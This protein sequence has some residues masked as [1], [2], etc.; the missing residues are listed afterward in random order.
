MSGVAPDTTPAPTRVTARLTAVLDRAAF[1][2]ALAAVAVSALAYPFRLS[3]AA[4]G[5]FEAPLGSLP[6]FEAWMRSPV[7]GTRMAGWLYAEFRPMLAFTASPL[8]LKQSLAQALLLAMCCA[9]AARLVL[10]AALEPARHAGPVRSRWLEPGPWLVAVFAWAAARSFPL[11]K[12]PAPWWASWATPVP[13]A[14]LF[15][16][17]ALGTGVVMGLALMRTPRPDRAR[18]VF[19]AAVVGCGFVVSSIALMQNSN[20]GRNSDGSTRWWWF[21]PVFDDAEGRNRMGSLIGHNTGLSSWLLFPLCFAFHGAM[22]APTRSARARGGVLAAMFALVIVYAQSRAVWL[23]AAAGLPGAGWAI[24][25]AGGLRWNRRARWTTAA[26][27]LA[28]LAALSVAPSVNPLARQRDALVDRLRLSVF[29]RDQLVRET[30]LRIVRA[31]LPLVAARPLSGHG[32]GAFAWVYGPAQGEYYRANLSDPDLGMTTRRTDVAHNDYL[33]WLVETGIIGA[34]LLAMAL[35]LTARRAVSAVR[36]APSPAEA[37][38]IVALVAPCA[39]ISIH[40]LVDFP[41]HI[42]PIALAAIASL[43]LAARGWN[44]ATPGAESPFAESPRPPRFAGSARRIAALAA[45]LGCPL[46]LYAAVPMIGRI[47]VSD[48]AFVDGANWINTA[49]TGDTAGSDR[50]H[51]MGNSRG[52]LRAAYRANPFNGEVYEKLAFSN[53]LAGQDRVR[54]LR[55]SEAAG[56]TSES[57]ALKTAART[58]FESA[59][60]NTITQLTYGELR[61]HTTFA[62]LGQAYHALWRLNPDPADIRQANYLDSARRHLQTALDYNPGDPAS[63]LEMSNLLESIPRPEPAKAAALRARMFRLSPPEARRVFLA[64][65]AEAA[66]RGEFDLADRR[67]DRPEADAPDDRQVILARASLELRRAYWPPPPLDVD[68]P[69]SATLAHRAG[70]LAAAESAMNRLRA[71]RP[72]RRSIS[73]LEVEYQRLLVEAHLAGAR[74]DWKAVGALADSAIAL[75]PKAMDALVLRE[76]AIVERGEDA[77]AVE[78]FFVK[79]GDESAR[80]VQRLRMSILGKPFLGA[81]QLAALAASPAVK[82][83]RLD[84]G[85]C[86]RA[87]AFLAGNGPPE[88]SAPRR[89][90]LAAHLARRFPAEPAVRRLLESVGAAPVPPPPLR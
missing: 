56:R 65:V 10:G 11:P 84:L 37:A 6:A 77:D 41:L 33:Q 31:S 43:A 8:V 64:P 67:M 7:W 54:D 13:A 55:V 46:L 40:A 16:L 82:P 23:L 9:L 47:V 2:L 61:W 3:D 25:R 53:L 63:I 51:A 78:R 62:T 45:A 70:H 68:P 89:R 60:Q 83:V 85:E 39:L 66:E 49:S 48:V 17:A 86:L 58:E 14:S 20:V 73:D 12:G 5:R 79:H 30:R 26:G 1:A 15:T 35:G 52:R 57:L 24:A 44:M 87:A 80:R 28:L 21:M 27:L 72:A 50:A 69:S 36:L 4:L 76:A 32:L 81:T 88:W 75:S 18:R 22:T 71:Q 34:A 42:A 19:M 59:V 74:G 38:R 90:A 29:S